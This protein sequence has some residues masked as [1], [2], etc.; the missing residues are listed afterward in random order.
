MKLQNLEA[1]E[2]KTRIKMREVKEEVSGY[3]ES[4]EKM[5]QLNVC[6]SNFTEWHN[7]RIHSRYEINNLKKIN[8]ER[9]KEIEKLKRK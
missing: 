8:D 5:L 4:V 7:G 9:V 3:K 6:K 2:D 1:E